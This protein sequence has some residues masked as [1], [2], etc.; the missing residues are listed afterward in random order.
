MSRRK[1]K[2]MKTVI[3]AGGNDNVG[4]VIPANNV[5]GKGMWNR[6]DNPPGVFA[7]G[8]VTTEISERKE[9]LFRQ[10]ARE[11]SKKK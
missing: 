9:N 3:Q 10:W 8:K 4:K 2:W 11:I 7:G 1:I 6:G 5:V